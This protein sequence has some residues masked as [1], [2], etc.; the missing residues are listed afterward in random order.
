[1]EFHFFPVFH[2]LFSL[3]I[4][5]PIPNLGIFF[6]FFSFFKSCSQ[7]T[8]WNT[9]SRGLIW[10]RLSLSY[11]QEE[12]GICFMFFWWKT[13][14]RA[15]PEGLRVPWKVI[16]PFQKARNGWGRGGE[17][18]QVWC[19]SRKLV[20]YYGTT[21]TSFYRGKLT[22]GLWFLWWIHWGRC[23]LGAQE[24]TNSQIWGSEW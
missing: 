17:Q 10:L 15:G 14:G 19:T 21:V 16:R 24:G 12:S 18:A 1:M 13:K 3:V 2:S 23:L 8:F 5:H 22:V 11:D 4:L 9:S 7:S 6:F 20:I